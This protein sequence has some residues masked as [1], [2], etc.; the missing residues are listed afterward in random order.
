MAGAPLRCYG[1]VKFV[2]GGPRANRATNAVEL[3]GTSNKSECT[4]ESEMPG[5]CLAVFHTAGAG[6]ETGSTT[7][8]CVLRPSAIALARYHVSY[9]AWPAEVRFCGHAKLGECTRRR[10]LGLLANCPGD[11]A[12]DLAALG[13]T[14]CPQAR[15]KPGLNHGSSL[16][17][18]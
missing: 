10:R 2:L 11:S 1:N 8:R 4:R 6:G 13:A 15:L 7:R 17:S 9:C 12:A 3:L 14:E 5:A 16:R 18:V